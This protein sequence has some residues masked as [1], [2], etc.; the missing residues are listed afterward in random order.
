[1]GE[2]ELEDDGD[3]LFGFEWLAQDDL[4][5]LGQAEKTK[6]SRRNYRIEQKT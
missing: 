4:V 1:M 5:E 3:L 6:Q 2:D